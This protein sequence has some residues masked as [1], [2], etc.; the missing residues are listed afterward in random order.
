MVSYGSMGFPW[1]FQRFSPPFPRGVGQW[2]RSGPRP[3]PGPMPCWSLRPRTRFS[4]VNVPRKIFIFM[5]IYIYR[6]VC[7]VCYVCRVCYVCHVC[8]VCIV[9]YCI[10]LY[11]IVLYCIVCRK[12]PYFIGKSMV[13]SLDFPLNQSIE[14][15]IFLMVF[16]LVF[17]RFS[18][19]FPLASMWIWPFGRCGPWQTPGPRLCWSL[20]PRML[21][22]N[23]PWN[24]RII[25]I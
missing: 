6:Y 4:L 15:T 11:C 2:A 12:G 7:Y 18:Y 1:L 10:V 20:R 23:V 19:G 3:T 21:R 22:G 25:E 17:L 5:Y 16:L 13:S 9:L 8:Y 24:R 14:I